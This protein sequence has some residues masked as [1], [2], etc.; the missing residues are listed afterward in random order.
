MERQQVQLTRMVF[1]DEIPDEVERIFR[2][3]A[4]SFSF[5]IGDPLIELTNLLDQKN[6]TLFLEKLQDF[7]EELAKADLLLEDCNGIVKSY[8]SIKSKDQHV[9][10]HTPVAN[11]QHVDMESLL[12]NI[13]EQ[14]SKAEELKKRLG[15]DNV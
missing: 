11:P 3:S 10:Q 7:R 4:S 12:Q 9:D 15:E 2:K 8:L 14:A 5:V 13:K 1:V 6:Y